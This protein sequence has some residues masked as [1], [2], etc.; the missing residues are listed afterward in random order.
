MQRDRALNHL[1]AIRREIDE[2][3]KL[4]SVWFSDSFLADDRIDHRAEWANAVDRFSAVADAHAAGRIDPDVVAQLI[5]VARVLA[6]FAPTLKRMQL[7]Q[8][9]SDDLKRLGVLSVA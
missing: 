4:E 3:T 2:L 7:R 5:D 6:V 8:I 1:R 9:P